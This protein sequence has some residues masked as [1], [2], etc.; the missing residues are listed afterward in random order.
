MVT[1]SSKGIG[2][3]I[4]KRCAVAGYDVVI[5]YNTDKEGADTTTQSCDERGV[6]TLQVQLEAKDEVSNKNLFDAVTTTFGQLDLLVVCAADEI[7]KDV[8]EA[9][10]DEWHH[11]LL[12]KIDGAFLAVK[13]GLPLLKKSPNPN[14]V[15]LSSMEGDFPDGSYLAYSVGEAG[16]NA[17]VKAWAVSLGTRYNVR[18]NAL[19]PGPVQTDLWR[20]AG[21]TDDAVWKQM[22]ERNP[23]KRIATV[24]DV[25]DA[26]LLITEDPHQYL[27]GNFI[28]VDGASHLKIH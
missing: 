23:L 19:C 11:V 24:E 7:P 20:K 16:L 27:S 13:Y 17:M 3:A 26:C 22:A 21:V 12:T 28:Y 14:I 25:A 8:E 6:R 5:T 4:A 9:T 1:G 18:V 15:I 10:Y 2:A